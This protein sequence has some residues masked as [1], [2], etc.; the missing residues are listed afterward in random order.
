MMVFQNNKSVT[1]FTLHATT[2]LAHCTIITPWCCG[3]EKKKKEIVQFAVV[4]HFFLRVE[5]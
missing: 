3:R 4:F 5:P 1:T 2:F